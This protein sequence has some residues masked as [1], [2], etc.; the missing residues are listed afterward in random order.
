MLREG[1]R[2]PALGKARSTQRAWRCPSQHHEHGGTE[3]PTRPQRRRKRNRRASSV[4]MNITRA[5]EQCKGTW[6]HGTSNRLDK[7]TALRE[8]GQA[9]VPDR[10]ATT[11]QGEGH[12]PPV[13]RPGQSQE[14]E[15]ELPIA[16]HWLCGASLTPAARAPLFYRAIFQMRTARPRQV[17]ELH[18]QLGPGRAG[19]AHGL[20]PE[21]APPHPAAPPL[22]EAP[23][24]CLL[25]A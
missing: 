3:H 10:V 7:S 13:E 20:C 17:K 8:K 4:S 18:P 12:S 24:S 25:C 11:S 15:R 22:G 14:P 19:P 2:P 1:H 6:A 16:E 9:L 5:R 21:L 23:G